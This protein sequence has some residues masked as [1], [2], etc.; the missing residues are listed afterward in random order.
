MLRPHAT[1]QTPWF[2]VTE[3]RETARLGKPKSNWIRPRE[4]TFAH[5]TGNDAAPEDRQAIDLR[6]YFFFG[7]IYFFL[8]EATIT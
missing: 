2:S 5:R 3:I 7:G 6:T 1:Q 8:I 4:I